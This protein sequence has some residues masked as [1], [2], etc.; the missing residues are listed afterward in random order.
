MFDG[1]HIVIVVD[2]PQPSRRF[3]IRQALDKDF[4]TAEIIGWSIK[5]DD[6]VLR[7][8]VFREHFLVLIRIDENIREGSCRVA[9]I[10]TPVERVQK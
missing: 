8:Q 3:I 4:V 1:K 10:A 6:K 5:A 7:K 2:I 9:D